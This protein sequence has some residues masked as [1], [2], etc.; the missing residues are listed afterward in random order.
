M[1]TAL[2]KLINKLII[3]KYKWIVTCG[4]NVFYDEPLEKYS[5][6]YYVES[7]DISDKE[8]EVKE[9]IELTEN[10]F[11][12]LGPESYQMLVYVDFHYDAKLNKEKNV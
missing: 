7:S 12:L 6:Y 3:R 8:I 11:K 9:I 1:I 5:V 2:N 4:I 10:L